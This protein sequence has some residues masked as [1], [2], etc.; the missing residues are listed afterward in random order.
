MR[1]AE[2]VK[3]RSQALK[4]TRLSTA[5][6]V[7][8]TIMLKAAFPSMPTTDETLSMWKH[9]LNDIDDASFLRAVEQVV[10]RT[11]QIYPGTNIIALIREASNVDLRIETNAFMEETS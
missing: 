3:T 9:F 10:T 8:G 4:P 2:V 11:T 6:F 5:S 7:Q 1:P